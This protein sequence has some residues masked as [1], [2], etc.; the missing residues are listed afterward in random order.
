MIIL[1]G[2]VHFNSRR[3]HRRITQLLIIATV[4]ILVTVTWRWRRCRVQDIRVISIRAPL[5]SSP[6]SCK[7]YT[8]KFLRVSQSGAD[9]GSTS[10]QSYNYGNYAG[11]GSQTSYAG[12]SN[13]VPSYT[14]STYGIQPG[15]GSTTV[16]TT[17]ISNRKTMA[18]TTP[19]TN[20]AHRIPV[21]ISQL[22]HHPGSMAAP[23]WQYGSSDVQNGGHDYYKPSQE[24][25]Y[26][27]NY[28]NTGYQTDSYSPMQTSG[29]YGGAYGTNYGYQDGGNQGNY[30][31][32]GGGPQVEF[33][34]NVGY[35]SSRASKGVKAKPSL[36]NNIAPNS[37]D[38]DGYRT[39]IK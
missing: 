36:T 17:V 38:E 15:S 34:M 16:A 33:T 26:A 29:G 3:G 25:G 30:A 20:T 35:G 2:K 4:R 18:T 9:Y 5:I 19:G 8:G 14:G 24:Y 1:D 28:G 39:K 32:Y 10:Q 21:A 6:P 12:S 31:N 22:T 27:Q 37:L 13:Q 11:T 7:S 23:S